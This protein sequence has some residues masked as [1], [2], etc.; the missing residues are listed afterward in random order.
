MMN[1]FLIPHYSLW[2]G[3]MNALFTHGCPCYIRGM[4]KIFAA[5][6]LLMVFASPA[7]A[8]SRHHHR[9]HHH[10]HHA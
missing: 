7:F 10:H 1:K 6:L 5:A 4:K 8:A 3:L 2:C 9:H